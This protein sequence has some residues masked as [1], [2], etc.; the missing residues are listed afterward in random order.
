MN[1]VRKKYNESQLRLNKKLNGGRAYQQCAISLMD[2]VRTK[3]QFDENGVSNYFYDYQNGAKNYVKDGDL[4]RA[5][6]A[7]SLESIRDNGKNKAYDCIL[8]V[9]GGVDSTFLALNAKKW[10]LRTLCVHFDNGWNSELATENIEN[11]INKCGFD[12]HTEVMDWNEFKQLQ[13]AYFSANVIDIE[14]VTDIGIFAAL[15]RISKKYDC[16]HILDGRNFKT[17]SV[18][19]DWTNKNPSNLL[20]IAEAFS[21]WPIRKFPMKSRWDVRRLNKLQAQIKKHAIL[22]WIEYDKKKAKQE[23]IETFG[24][25]DYGGKHYESVFTRFYQGYILPEK[26][27]ID[28]RKAHLSNLIFSN[29]ITKEE[30]L[31]EIQEPIYPNEILTEDFQFV[32]KKLDFSEKEFYH[33]ID[34]PEVQHKHYGLSRSP[35]KDWRHF[36]LHDAIA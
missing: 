15:D 5:Q 9:S 31:E 3:I 7:H 2:T 16:Y 19:G 11:I 4:G 32:M 35:W 22:D 27:G 23:I 26:F 36:R 29:Q 25:R 21:V 8:G 14:A 34:A 13:K 17:E 1:S 30:A 12:L 28:K 24:W 20:N 18:L 6:L 33:Y 10:G